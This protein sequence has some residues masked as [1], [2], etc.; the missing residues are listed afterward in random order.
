M[1][2]FNAICFL[3]RHY[4]ICLQSKKEIEL[5]MNQRV[6]FLCVSSKSPCLFIY[7]MYYFF[8]VKFIRKGI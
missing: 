6:V 1:H 8:V 3:D 5:L 4:L 7:L 2:K